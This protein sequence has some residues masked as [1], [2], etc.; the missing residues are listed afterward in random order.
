MKLKKQRLLLP[1]ELVYHVPL[2]S[3]SQLLQTSWLSP[4]EKNKATKLVLV[5]RLIT[6]Y[7]RNEISQ[8]KNATRATFF[9]STGV[10][11]HPNDP[12]CLVMAN[13]GFQLMGY[14]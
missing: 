2:G 9:E 7:S 13:L 11:I 8:G 1:L 6:F 4:K 3:R 10:Q 12:R 14:Q 5:P